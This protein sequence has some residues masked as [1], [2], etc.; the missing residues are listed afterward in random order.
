MR[1][2][3]EPHRR[4]AGRRLRGRR[5]TLL[6]LLLFL[7]AIPA[8]ADG[9]RAS[10]KAAAPALEAHPGFVDL[11]AS[12]DGLFQPEDLEVEISVKGPLLRLVAE[13]TRG[14]DPELSSMLERLAGVEVSVFKVDDDRRPAVRKLIDRTS[15]QLKRDGWDA[16]LT[17][18]L[19]GDHG[20]VYMRLGDDGL[21]LGIAGVYLQE[22]GEAVFLNIVGTVDPTMIGRLA[23]RFNLGGFAEAEPAEE[24]PEDAG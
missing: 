6:L 9:D 23:N 24:T 21:P 4:R 7:A 13:G 14:S 16:A 20:F 1:R 19:R 12:A 8:A 18:R 5:T 22:S 15:A 10:P 3:P 11:T 17:I 2:P